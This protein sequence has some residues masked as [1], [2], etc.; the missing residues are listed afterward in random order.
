M[1]EGVETQ[2]IWDK[3]REL[4]CSVAQGY[5]LS[6]PVPPEQLAEWLVERRGDAPAGEAA[7]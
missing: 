4:G 1:A 3:L 2:E 6:R 5:F 7:A